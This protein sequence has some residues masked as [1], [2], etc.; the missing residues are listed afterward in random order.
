[1]RKFAILLVLLSLLSQSVFAQSG[2]EFSKA[3][4]YLNRKGEVYFSFPKTADIDLANLTRVIS[5]DGIKDQQ[6]FAYANQSEFQ[7]FLSMNIPYSVLPHPGDAPAEMYDP[8]RGIWQFDTY[9]TYPEYITMMQTFATNYPDLCRLVEIGTTVQGRKQK[10]AVLS[11]NVH[12]REAE[13]RFMYTSSMHGDETT[14]YVTMLRMI[15]YLLTNYGSNT[16]ITDLLNTTEI[17][18]MP[19]ENPDGTYRGGDNSVS[20]ATRSNANNVDLNRNYPNPVDG[21]NPTG[22]WQPENISFMGLSDTVQFVMSANF[23]G[24]AELVNYP[25]DSWTASQ[26]THADDNWWQ[27]V[28]RNF[29]DTTQHYAVAGYLNDEN[30]GITNGGDWYVVYGSRQDYFD[31]YQLCREF[32]VEI[33]STKLVTAST[34][35]NYWNYLHRALINYMKE[36]HNGFHGIITDACTGDPIRAKVFVNSHDRDSSHIYSDLPHGNYYRPIKAGTY[37][38][39]FSAPGYTSVTQNVTTTDGNGIT[40]D[41]QLTPSAAPVANFSAD[42]TSGCNPVVTFSNL[43]T[44]PSGSTYLWDFGDG[45][46]S[47]EETPTH[48]YAA[49]GDYDVS[50]TVTNTCTGNDSEVK[51]NYISLTIATAPTATGNARC[52]SGTLDLTASGAGNLN[53]YDASTGGTLLETGTSYTT[54]TISTTTTYYVESEAG[55]SVYVGGNSD[56]TTNG[57]IFTATSVHYLEFDC[58]APVT[59]TSVIVNASTAGNRV[60]SLL[61]ASSNV[62][63]SGTFTLTTGVQTV[64]LN[65]D[66]PVGNNLRLAGPASPYLYRNDAGCAYPYDIGGIISITNSSAGTNPTGY[67]YYFYDW[68]ITQAGCA[69]PR[70]PVV[71]TVNNSPVVN[72]G[73]DQEIPSGTATSLAGLATGGSG[74]YSWSWEP[75]ASLVS[76]NVQNPT[77][78]VLTDTTEFFLTVTDNTTSCIGFDTVVVNTTASTLAVSVSA[79][80]TT[81]C[82]GTQ[83]QLSSSPSG[84]TGSYTYSWTS[85]PAGFTS[86]SQNPTVSP[87]ASTTY[88]LTIDDG[89]GTESSS[90][91]VSVLPLPNAVAGSPQDVCYGGSVLLTANGGT[92]Y[93]WSNGAYTATTSVTPSATTT[94]TVTVSNSQGCSATDAVS[95][96]VLTLPDVDAGPDTSICLGESI[97]LTPSGA[98]TYSVIPSVVMPAMVATPSVTT[99]YTITGTAANGCSAS[100]N[101]VI[102]VLDVDVVA[103]FSSLATGTNVDFTNT[104]TNASTYW[105]DF[106]D[107]T[108]SALHDPSHDYGQSGIYTVTLIASNPCDQDTTTALIDITVGISELRNGGILIYPNPAGD[109]VMIETESSERIEVQIFD[110]AGRELMSVSSEEFPHRISLSALASGFYLLK[111]VSNGSVAKAGLVKR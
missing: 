29:A 94:Y 10:F 64:N 39:T 11:D 55:G 74:S 71:A 107:G 59:L 21:P 9:P 28:S 41:V 82:A 45:E 90:V 104:S 67:Y 95:I 2:T 15:N 60:F 24:G 99:T 46:T 13:P 86:G 111:V 96:T 23:H 69:S 88:Y 109:H 98:L 12:T 54:P 85:N 84:G 79:T 92:D 4:A 93:H 63:T 17:W 50:L 14:G 3:Q 62:I 57:S 102:T 25:F 73:T 32:T 43:S 42:N 97:T 100:D 34:L 47:T 106:G 27:R 48:V 22:S 80:P 66:I 65:F 105:W 1:M 77:T 76:A 16:E 83:V 75:S 33:S 81:V 61:D 68:T 53:W 37:S 87:T 91:T 70:T 44:G 103:G 36:V 89:S 5:L 72:A 49:S 26:K 108:T 8:S 51:T 58:N 78:V 7:Q 30:N 35:P 56:T 31:Y 6:V 18:I 52:G 19:L 110:V 101:V 38:V 40:V 20:G